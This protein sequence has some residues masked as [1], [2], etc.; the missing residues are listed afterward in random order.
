[1]SSKRLHRADRF[2][3]DLEYR[4]LIIPPGGAGKGSAFLGRPWGNF[5]RVVFQN[6]NL[7]NIVTPAGWERTYFLSSILADKTLMVT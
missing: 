6:S 2:E 1:V 5:A 3:T 4:N 7:E